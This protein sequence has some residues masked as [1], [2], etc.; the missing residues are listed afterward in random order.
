M[1]KS[2]ELE[3]LFAR[4]DVEL[5]GRVLK[6]LVLSTEELTWCQEK[7]NSVEIREG[8]VTRSCSYS[9]FPH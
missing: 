4:I 2:H 5:V 3:I 7:L 9:Q 1:D 8:K 6:M